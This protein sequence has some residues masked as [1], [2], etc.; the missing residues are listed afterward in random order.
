MKRPGGPRGNQVKA[1]RRRRALIR[2]LGGKCAVCGSTE[3]L[4]LD[5]KA[6]RDW[7]PSTRS[8]TQRLRAYQ[9]EAKKG[10]VQVLCAQHHGAKTRDDQKTFLEH[11]LSDEP[12]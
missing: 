7:T 3:K 1:I 4:E 10:N 6:P 11:L 8:K 2:A 9:A 12:F 5:H